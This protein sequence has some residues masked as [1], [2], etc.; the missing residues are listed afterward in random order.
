MQSYKLLLLP[1]M[2]NELHNTLHMQHQNV[3]VFCVCDQIT[4]DLA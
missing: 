1:V 2:T 3:N 4:P